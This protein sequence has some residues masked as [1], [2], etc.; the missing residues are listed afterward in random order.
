MVSKTTKKKLA[1][2][3]K[4]P[5]NSYM[6]VSPPATISMLAFFSP[7]KFFYFASDHIAYQVEAMIVNSFLP[8]TPHL[9]LLPFQSSLTVVQVLRTLLFGIRQAN[10]AREKQQLEKR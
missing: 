10:S 2:H 1:K 8:T 4:D 5:T 6:S 9:P 3:N 7:K